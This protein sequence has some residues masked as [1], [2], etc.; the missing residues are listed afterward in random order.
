MPKTPSIDL[1]PP[2]MRNGFTVRVVR[3]EN[4]DIDVN[5]AN[6]SVTHKFA[7]G[8]KIKDDLRVDVTPTHVQKVPT[9]ALP[10]EST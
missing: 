9:E 10:D 7:M 2:E 3:Y 5:P 6:L 8:V 4:G 1:L